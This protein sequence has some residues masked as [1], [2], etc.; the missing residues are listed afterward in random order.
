MGR[1][2]CSLKIRVSVVRFRPWLPI[3]ALEPY[4]PSPSRTVVV[5]KRRV[6]SQHRF[7]D[8]YAVFSTAR[9]QFSYE[10]CQFHAP[11]ASS[12]PDLWRMR[13]IA[14]TLTLELRIPSG[15]RTVS[16]SVA[17]SVRY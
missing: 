17:A 9:S 15:E 16:L 14:H 6:R 5:V 2:I 10:A 11:V 7:A 3:Q 8:R 12:M 13:R 1:E 4:V